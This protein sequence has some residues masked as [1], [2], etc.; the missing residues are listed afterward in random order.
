VAVDPSN[1]AGMNLTEVNLSLLQG[2]RNDIGRLVAMPS[3]SLF[4]GRPLGTLDTKQSSARGN[5]GNAR[6]T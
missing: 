2:A 3:S 4:R 1:L 5:R 6:G